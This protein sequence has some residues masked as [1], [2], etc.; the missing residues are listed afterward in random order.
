MSKNRHLARQLVVKALF[1]HLSQVDQQESFS[2]ID[3]VIEHF[4]KQLVDETFARNLFEMCL[5]NL[6][7]AFDLI[8]E[9]A[10]EWPIEK[11]AQLDKVILVLG[12][13]EILY[14]M[15]DVPPV[16]AINEAV[17]LAKE[18]ADQSS[19]KFINGVLS[20]LAKIK[21]GQEKLQANS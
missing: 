15:P 6:D 14:P 2:A 19:A 16:V 13:T 11:I 5:K 4:G 3:Y 12:M 10:P 17:E 9:F 18:F 21:L 20:N 7:N 1:V 8:T